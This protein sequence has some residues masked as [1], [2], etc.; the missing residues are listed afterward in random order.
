M[1]KSYFT[2]KI[3]QFKDKFVNFLKQKKKLKALENLSSCKRFANWNYI[4]MLKQCFES[5]FLEEPE[6]N[7]L[8]HMIEKNFQELE[9]LAWS[10][11]T[12]WL[13]KQMSELA[14][15]LP[16]SEQQLYMPF[17]PKAAPGLY[18]INLIA[19]TQNNRSLRT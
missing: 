7:F 17:E 8:N 3:E 12:R 14:S 19:A 9:Y 4:Q 11:K 5:G 16:A 13:K 6:E 1:D 10:H 2:L 15:Q 18:P